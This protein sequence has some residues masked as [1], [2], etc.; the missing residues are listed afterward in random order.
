V[1]NYGT[2]TIEVDRVSRVSIA[3][4]RKTL[5]EK[6][7]D[8]MR[9]NL[10]MRHLG[11]AAF[12]PQMVAYTSLAESSGLS[13]SHGA[14]RTEFVYDV[15]LG[16]TIGYPAVRRN[17]WRDLIGQNALTGKALPDLE[18]CSSWFQGLP[19]PTVRIS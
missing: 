5:S 14:L 11:K 17:V 16:G 7:E 3:R 8:S 18:R 9:I 13:E 19:T 12:N 10:G 15:S 4:T 1:K 2:G 6:P